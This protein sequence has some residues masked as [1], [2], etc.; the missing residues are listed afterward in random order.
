[1]NWS[2]LSDSLAMTCSPKEC[3]QCR[4]E[5]RL[6]RG[7][8][9]G[10][11][12]G[13]ALDGRQ[14]AMEEDFAAVLESIPA[15]DKLWRLGNYEILEEIGRGGM[16]VIYRARQR[17]SRRIVALKRVLSYHAESRETLA[18]FRREA[19]AASS[20]DHPN[21]LPIYEVGETVEGIPYFSMKYAPGGSLAEIGA[22]LR[23]DA[24]Q[25][26]RLLA[27]VTRAVQSAH[28][29]G[30]LHRDL[31]PGNI[32]LDG[33]G[34]PLVSDFGLAKWLD[35]ST[36]LTRTLTIFGTPG[37]IAPEQAEGPAADLTPAADIYS[38]GA[39][40]FDLLA[41]RPPFIGEHALAVIR[42]AADKPAPKLRSL[43]QGANR[44]LETICAR[45]LERDPSGR[46]LS[47]GDLAEDLERWLEGRSII[48]RPVSPPV[49]VWRWGRRNPLPAAAVIIAFG[50][51]G[52]MFLSQV[53]QLQLSKKVEADSIYR[54]SIVVVPFLDLNTAK[55][56]AN[57][58]PS[59][60]HAAQAALSQLG[61]ARVI[62]VGSHSWPGVGKKDDIRA[63]AQ[64]SGARTVL[65]GTVRRLAAK[66]SVSVHL[67]ESSSGETLLQKRFVLDQAAASPGQLADITATALSAALD[68]H[69]AADA[70]KI[71]PALKNTVASEYIRAGQVFDHRRGKTDTEHALQ[72][73]ESA[74]TAEPSSAVARCYFVFTAVSSYYSNGDPKILAKAEQRGREALHLNPQLA[75]T[76]RAM[77]GLLYAKGQLGQAMEEMS[78]A[79]EIGGVAEDPVVGLAQL[80][81]ESGRPDLALRWHELAKHI[82]EN[83]ADYEF[84]MADCWAELHEDG[85]AK[86]I[87]KRVSS[88][89]PDLPEGWIGLCRLRLLEGDFDGARELCRENLHR[90]RDYGF[91]K[92]MAAQVEFFAR[93]YLEAQRLYSELSQSDAAGGGTFAGSITYRSALGRIRYLR[94]D[95]SAARSILSE[96][97]TRESAAL[98]AAPSHPQILY[99]IAALESALDEKEL[100][101]RHLS[102]AIDAGWLDDRS[103]RLDPRFDLIRGDPRFPAILLAISK[104]VHMLRQTLDR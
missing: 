36:D 28:R 94:G 56:D 21:I 14:Q 24:R 88:L 99:R 44:D 64:R 60:A 78:L 74:I 1:M 5:A 43:V 11:L 46:Y 77:T 52:A 61:P 59:F 27:K 58:A 69:P 75:E 65:M 95:E 66:L 81:R 23:G 45:C 17:H 50:L 19:E 49:R 16:G 51:A 83:P 98:E 41:G 87:Y 32:L 22:A 53:Q 39:I 15:P 33:R 2:G 26:V 79:L 13:S 62:E 42:Q 68:G 86:A 104:R 12:L 100:A 6:S 57:F 102:A 71:D 92:Q 47:A 85:E 25:I 38:L 70:G 73:F 40:L 97:L 90:Y 3:P 67:V 30:I 48:A 37:Y 55:S 34:E 8:C 76:H 31:K 72:C 63:L 4:T 91:A 9:L 20:L 7:L 54:R 80:Y 93:D 96:E 89:H 10:C 35:T 84:T 101:F 29:N 103:L 82:Q 18:R